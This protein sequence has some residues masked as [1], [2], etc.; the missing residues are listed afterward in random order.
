MLYASRKLLRSC[1]EAHL[2]QHLEFRIPAHVD[3]VMEKYSHLLL[4]FRSVESVMMDYNRIISG[5][6][7]TNQTESRDSN[8]NFD[9]YN[10]SFWDSDLFLLCKVF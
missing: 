2:W 7:D 9:Y 5:K 3:I 6:C 4:L 1:E 10:Y 8:L